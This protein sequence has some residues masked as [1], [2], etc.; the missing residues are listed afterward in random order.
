MVASD[1]K[2][3]VCTDPSMGTGYKIES[4]I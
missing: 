2:G 4:I 1:F 3:F